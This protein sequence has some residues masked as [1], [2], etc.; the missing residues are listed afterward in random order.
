MEAVI[1]KR[2]EKRGLLC[3]VVIYIKVCQRKKKERVKVKPRTIVWLLPIQLE[4]IYKESIEALKI[5]SLNK[6]V[7]DLLITLCCHLLSLTLS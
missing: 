7:T 1:D 3:K 6:Y 5:F 4:D 2:K